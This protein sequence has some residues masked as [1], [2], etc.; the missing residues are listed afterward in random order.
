MALRYRP[1][2]VSEPSRV[3]ANALSGVDGML[4]DTY[5]MSAEELAELL[6]SYRRRAAGQRS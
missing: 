2:S 5:G 1:G 4:P 6:E 3:I